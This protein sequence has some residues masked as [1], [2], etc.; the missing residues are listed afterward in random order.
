[1]GE[2]GT[3][4]H[5]ELLQ[6]MNLRSNLLSNLNLLRLETVLLTTMPHN[7]LKRIDLDKWASTVADRRESILAIAR[8]SLSSADYASFKDLVNATINLE[9]RGG[10]NKKNPFKRNSRKY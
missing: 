9:I 4:S 3:E 7:R 6:Y 8:E 2:E 10:I 5:N 1:M